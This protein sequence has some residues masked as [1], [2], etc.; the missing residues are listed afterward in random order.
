M[1]KLK[2]L[3]ELKNLLDSDSITK[4]EHDS[5]KK[6]ILETKG[7]D[8]STN[9]NTQE[10]TSIKPWNKTGWGKIIQVLFWPL[11]LFM[12]FKV[13]YFSKTTRY[14]IAGIVLLSVIMNG[15][16]GGGGS[17]QRACECTD[18]L[19]LPRSSVY[20]AGAKLKWDNCKSKFGSYY[21]ANDKCVKSTR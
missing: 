17:N 4:E 11:G 21:T 16:G 3:E 9:T 7:N 8:N 10:S 12:M 2:K 18:I 1:D 19:M 15:V 6:E 13:P 5:L 20:G 14:I